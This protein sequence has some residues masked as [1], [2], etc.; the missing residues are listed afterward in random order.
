[1]F[2]DVKR[3][4][5]ENVNWIKY[6][7][8]GFFPRRFISSKEQRLFFITFGD[9]LIQPPGNYKLRA[10]KK[11]EYAGFVKM[12]PQSV[13]PFHILSVAS[14]DDI[15][16]DAEIG[17]T[18]SIVD[19]DE[20]I[21]KV[22]L[23]QDDQMAIINNLITG[24]FKKSCAKR[25]FDKLKSESSEIV[26]EVIVS[27]EEKINNGVAVFHIKDIM[28]S[29]YI[30]CD[31]KIVEARGKK[32]RVVEEG[33]L[34]IEELKYKAEIER[35]ENERTK[36]Q[37]ELIREQKLAEAMNE[38]QLMNNKK[39][40]ENIELEILRKKAEV[41]QLPEG[42]TVLYPVQT[43]ALENQELKEKAAFWQAN[44]ND[45]K[46]QAFLD[47]AVKAGMSQEAIKNIGM[48]R[49]L[50]QQQYNVSVSSKGQSPLSELVEKVEKEENSS[51]LD[52]DTDK[53]LDK[54]TTT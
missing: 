25:E 5:I 27:I 13:L 29:G 26:E 15:L 49:E 32:I 36:I 53:D 12:I 43:F 9:V 17:L 21:K 7:E 35:L 14:N 20:C 33:R 48:L 52:N 19:S 24:A 3:Y 4:K 50:I 2:R 40:I 22:V 11:V 8:L 47:L 31:S 28:L 38:I 30:P 44:Y 18:L 23:S 10:S 51:S 6:E 46:L 16:F 41:A 37:N 34:Q 42:R 45:K 1:M 39:E 54:S